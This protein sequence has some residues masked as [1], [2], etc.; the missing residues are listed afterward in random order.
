MSATTA[1]SQAAVIN[2]LVVDYESTNAG[3]RYS[4][5][6]A[7][8]VDNSTF[9][10][11][12]LVMQGTV[13]SLVGQSLDGVGLIIAG[14]DHLR[15]LTKDDALAVANHVAT[16]ASVLA[17]GHSFGEYNTSG[18]GT[19]S[20][21]ALL[22]NRFT[23]NLGTPYDFPTAAGVIP[24]ASAPAGTPGNHTAGGDLNNSLVSATASH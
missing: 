11:H 7:D 12:T 19:D 10:S 4:N 2:V 16:G 8:L 22:T 23:N 5:F 21:S 9:A 13:S 20:L 14:H 24:T 6:F 15:S 3:A 17:L 1:I 18:V